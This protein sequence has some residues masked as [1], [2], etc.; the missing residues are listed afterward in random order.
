MKDCLGKIR[1]SQSRYYME[2]GFEPTRIIMS[3][4]FYDKCVL[5]FNSIMILKHADKKDYEVFGMK[6]R[7]SDDVEDF[8]VLG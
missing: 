7:R 5:E 3:N 8:E 6:I 2:K 4:S 1:I